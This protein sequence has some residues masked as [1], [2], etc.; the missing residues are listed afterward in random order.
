[1]QNLLVQ[2]VIQK[3]HETS[4]LCFTEDYEAEANH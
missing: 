2:L 3:A 1:M 4:K